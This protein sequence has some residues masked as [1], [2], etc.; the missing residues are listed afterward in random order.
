[1]NQTWMQ[2]ILRDKSHFSSSFTSSLAISA[3]VIFFLSESA[4]F[5]IDA[6]SALG[7]SAINKLASRVTFLNGETRESTFL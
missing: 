1:M 7:A 5:F 6:T 4:W 3:G 2:S